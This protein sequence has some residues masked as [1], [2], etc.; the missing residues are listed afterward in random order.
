[1]PFQWYPRL[2][3]RLQARRDYMFKHKISVYAPYGFLH[4]PRSVAPSL[5]GNNAPASPQV[6][7]GQPSQAPALES[8]P[9]PSMSSGEGA[10]EEAAITTQKMPSIEV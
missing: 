7:A 8:I 5:L 1:M 10:T 2:W 9:M 4:I 3:D 6:I